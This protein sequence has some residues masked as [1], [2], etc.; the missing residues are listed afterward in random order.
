[1]WPRAASAWP[2]RDYSTGSL[3]EAHPYQVHTEAAFYTK[4]PQDKPTDT[5]LLQVRSPKTA[6]ISN[7]QRRHRP[8]K[9]LHNHFGLRSP[10]TQ[11]TE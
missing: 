6:T 9:G 11:E 5:L 8:P 10:S 2:L 1:M 4:I 7:A 3:I